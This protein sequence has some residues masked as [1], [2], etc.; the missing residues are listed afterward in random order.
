LEGKKENEL[1]SGAGNGRKPIE[2][3]PWITLSKP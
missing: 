1:F 3:K 2:E